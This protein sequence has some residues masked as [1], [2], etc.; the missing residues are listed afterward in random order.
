MSSN[1][2]LL[3][4][5]YML[6]VILS[7][8]Y[9]CI[10]VK[11]EIETDIAQPISI[12][13]KP[14]IEMSETLVRS[15]RGDMI[16]FLPKDWFFVDLENDISSDVFAVAVN[17]DYTLSAVFSVIR[18]TEK[19]NELFEKEALI[20]LARA[21]LAK[22]QQKSADAIKL[23]GKYTTVNMGLLKFCKYSYTT[24]E[25]AITA[26]SAVFNSTLDQS[27]EFSLIPMNINGNPL[28]PKSEIDEIFNSILTTIQY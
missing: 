28:P 24:S 23:L 13:P 25:G 17:P 15:Q 2:I 1:K 14:T 3:I 10:I 16:A 26:Q 20:G 21:S 22:K 19:V 8:F 6:I 7:S 12:S 27:Y 4:I 18:K 11:E 5:K 9:S